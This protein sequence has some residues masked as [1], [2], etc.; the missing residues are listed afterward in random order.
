MSSDEMPL[1]TSP[2]PVGGQGRVST[3]WWG[4]LCLIATE[5]ILFAYLIFSFAYLGTQSSSSWP[6]GGK[7]SL[8]LALPDTIVLLASSVTAIFAKRAFAKRRRMPFQLA[9]GATIILGVGFV[10]VQGVEWAK[11]PFSLNSS[12]YSSAYFTLTGFHLAHVVVG[13][14]M[15]A[16]VLVW[17]LTGRLRQYHGH[18]ELVSIYWHFVDLV[19]LCVFAT[20]YLV[21]WL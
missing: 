1:T 19:W 20:I 6:P 8:W 2:L 12:S 13:L 5:G 11:K 7:P 17:S 15:L 9:W 4:M 14:L 21:P 3:G 16:A 18:V 10:T